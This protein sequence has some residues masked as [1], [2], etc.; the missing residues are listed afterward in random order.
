MKLLKIAF[1]VILAVIASSTEAAVLEVRCEVRDALTGNHIPDS[2]VMVTVTP[3][4]QPATHDDGRYVY[5]VDHPNVLD[6]ESVAV[7]VSADGDYWPRR[8]SLRRLNDSEDFDRDIEV[9]LV[10]ESSELSYETL[11]RFHKLLEG[12]EIERVLAVFEA[13]HLNLENRFGQYGV[14][15]RY[16]FA[17]SLVAACRVYGYETCSRASTI[18]QELMSER[19][20]RPNYSD[21][22]SREGLTM[23]RLS[24]CAKDAM[25]ATIL[26]RAAGIKRAYRRGGPQL[27]R[28][29]LGWEEILAAKP[30]DLVMWRAVG[31]TPSAAARD[32]GTA[33]VQYADFLSK[34]PGSEEHEIVSRLSRGTELLS[35]AKEMGDQSPE[36]D[37]SLDYA[38]ARL[39]QFSADQQ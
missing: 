8:I 25:T 10:P 36:T 4:P 28:A 23:Q 20:E 15:V 29:A 35:T 14:H 18:C 26:T 12:G 38:R 24:E 16:N 5:S 37:R 6:I 7:Q 22:F 17:R 31:W 32:A 39:S 19:R 30:E 9:W 1:S 21:I 27:L 3:P 11:A 34:Q 33:Y 2:E 13:A